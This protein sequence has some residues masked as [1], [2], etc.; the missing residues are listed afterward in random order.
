[1][2]DNIEKEKLL[3]DPMFAKKPPE[4][5]EDSEKGGI[6]GKAIVKKTMFVLFL[7]LA[8]GLSLF[9]SFNALGKETYTYTKKDNGYELSEFNGGEGDRILDVEFVQDESG[10]VDHSETVTSVRNYAVC[11]NEYLEF[12]YV[13]K[14]VTELESN[15]FYYCTNLKAVIVDPD[16]RVYTSVDG[17]LFSKDMTE[18]IMHPIKNNEYRT[19][20]S[21]GMNA[22]VTIDGC[23][24][25]IEE[26]ETV[27]GYDEEE[28]SDDV[29]EALKAVGGKYVIP[30][31]VTEI[32]DFCFNY[33][34][35]MSEITIPGGVK[36]IGQMA[37]FKCTRLE[38]IYIPDGV[39]SLG[40][41]AF[42]YIYNSEVEDEKNNAVTL[43][44][45]YVPASVKTIGHHAFF[46][47]L[48]VDAVY[49]G[50]SGED[51]VK[52]GESWL[53]KQN[54]RSMKSV[55]VIYGAERRD[56]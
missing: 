6:F 50:A 39:E 27:I 47:C 37:F 1:M 52:T 56:G 41:D 44:Y 4:G 17:V 26:F 54:K 24:A 12:I 7:A 35:R 19:A 30:E 31:T 46:G 8:I 21:L 38:S 55:D 5:W 20:L 48:G 18:I 34:D 43:T 25:F 45:I 29:K 49:L 15:C 2:E 3:Y 10:A 33:S 28:R 14:D 40:P 36:R 23:K 11:C 51:D 22:P 9:F 53:P 13:G 16:N 32:A 42:S